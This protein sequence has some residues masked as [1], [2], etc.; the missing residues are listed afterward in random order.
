[1]QT[2]LH[3]STAYSA[4]YRKLL[5]LSSCL[6]QQSSWQAAAGLIVF[7]CQQLVSVRFADHAS[8]D[9]SPDQ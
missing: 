7:V 1:M 3:M 6:L 2:V 9:D 5:H 8:G 4:T